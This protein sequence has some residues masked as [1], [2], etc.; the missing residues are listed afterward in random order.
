M[1]TVGQKDLM[2]QEGVIQLEGRVSVCLFN[3]LSFYFLQY[4]THS[5]SSF[6]GIPHFAVEPHDVTVVANVSL[7]LQC[8]A[9]GPPEPVRI[10]WLQNGGPLNTLQD[11]VSHSP[12]TLNLTGKDFSLTFAFC[13][14]TAHYTGLKLKP[15]SVTVYL[16]FCQ[17]SL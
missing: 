15:H 14:Q 17:S 12:S 2:S 16:L 11:P 3:N 1:A 5:S 8:M 9:H 13:L 6:P 4:L 10:I 7:S